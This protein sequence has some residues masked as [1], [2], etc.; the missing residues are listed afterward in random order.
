MAWTSLQKEAWRLP[1][2]SS[3]ILD[4]AR[5]VSA[6]LRKEDLRGAIVGGVAV[7]L[8]GHLRATLDVDVFVSGPLEPLARA[9]RRRGFTFDTRRREF[10]RGAVPV[11]P[12]S[13]AQ[14]G[15][16]PV[17]LIDI[18]GITTVSL[19]DLVGIKLRSGTRSVLR[20][21]DLA[22]LIALIRV[23][24]LTSAF[25]AR[26]ERPLRAEFRKLVRAVQRGDERRRR[27]SCAP[28]AGDRKTGSPGAVNSGTLRG[29]TGREP[30]TAEGSFSG[31]ARPTRARPAPPRSATGR[32]KCPRPSDSRR[33]SGRR[34]SRSGIARSSS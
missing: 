22:D 30:R 4:V 34:R 29:S 32:W 25:A 21:Q 27:G 26:L 10:R 18:S 20:A 7:G 15:S 11:H 33:R 2:G 9:L 28:R 17:R 13:E 1:E 23:R 5:E 19:P 8:H 3:A 6:I 12:L 16:P 14:L 24:G 31:R